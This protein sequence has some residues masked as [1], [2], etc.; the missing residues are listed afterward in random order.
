M[1]YQYIFGSLQYSQ[2]RPYS[3]WRLSTDSLSIYETYGANPNVPITGAIDVYAVYTGQL[4]QYIVNWIVDNKSVAQSELQNYGGGYNL[5][6]PTIKE[7]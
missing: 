1:Q 5:A 4:Q 7:V 6:S 3:G 2:Y